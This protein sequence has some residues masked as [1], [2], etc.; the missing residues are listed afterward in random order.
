MDLARLDRDVAAAVAE[1]RD[2]PASID[3]DAHRHV[4]GQ[5]TLRALE[6]LSPTPLRDA[7]LASVTYLTALRVSQPALKHAVEART[8]ARV[9]VRDVVDWRGLVNGMLAA[10]FRDEA[11]V[12]FDAWPTLAA[13]LQG[14]AR[15]VQEIR[16]EA[17]HRL[18][19]DDVAL[20]YLGVSRR[21]LVSNAARFITATTDLARAC[22][23]RPP[24]EPHW[25]L[26]LN[27]RLAREAK[28]GAWPSRLT[29]RTAAALLPGLLSGHGVRTNLVS[30][31]AASECPH[32]HGAA[33]FA[34]ALSEIGAAFRR[35]V[36]PASVPFT[37]RQPPLFPGA[38]RTG[39]L[40]ASIVGEPAFHSRVLELAAGP[41]RD[42]ARMLRVA[43]LLHARTM[44]VQ[45][46]IGEPTADFEA[47]TDAVF[48]APLPSAFHRVWPTSSDEDVARF[49]ALL[50]VYA[51]EDALR[52]REG[53][54]WFRNPR[55]FGTLADLA[56]APMKP[57]VDGLAFAR[58]FEE[59]LD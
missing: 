53:D 8:K 20:H 49:V 12:Y 30:Q 35:S 14:A 38:Y 16:Q 37:E 43:F 58:R 48:G 28:N 19:I 5:R 25:P 21:D 11:Q 7:L 42:Q 22:T 4:S 57:N 27:I 10:Q 52:D 41:A 54:D 34:R 6:A 31:V 56:C 36:S 47:L 39:F 44:A 55:A 50:T 33:S 40:F 26:D 23:E 32:A 59:L 24:G 45:I 18:G 2:D 1:W 3:W 17:F 29:W 13:L 51:L 46:A 15:S 9:L